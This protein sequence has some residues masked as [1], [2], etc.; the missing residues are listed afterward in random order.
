MQKPVTPARSS[1]ATPA[2]RV[3]E[4]SKITKPVVSKVTTA[5]P[6]FD[7]ENLKWMLGGIIVVALGFILMAGGKSSNPRVFDDKDVYSF[8]RITLSPI[9]IIVGFIIEIFAIMRKPA[10]KKVIS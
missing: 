1:T 8:T 7:K 3:G 2:S 6:L 9:L 5:P 10:E 4:S